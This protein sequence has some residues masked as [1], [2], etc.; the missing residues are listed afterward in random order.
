MLWVEHKKP[1]EVLRFFKGSEPQTAWGRLALARA[2]S[3]Q[4]NTEGAHAQ[5]RNAWHNDGMSAELEQQVL[6]AHAELLTRAD[7][8]VRMGR[9]LG[10]GRDPATRTILAAT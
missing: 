5:V 1:S 7:H 9:R 2:L 4:G 8:K 6:K 10:A 3:A